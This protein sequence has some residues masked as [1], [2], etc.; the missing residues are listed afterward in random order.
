MKKLKFWADLQHVPIYTQRSVLQKAYSF[1]F[2]APYLPPKY[3]IYTRWKVHINIRTSTNF[4]GT[5]AVNLR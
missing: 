4:G 3:K 2:A 5:A 1:H